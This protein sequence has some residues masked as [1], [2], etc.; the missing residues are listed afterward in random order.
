MVQRSQGRTDA[1][2]LLPVMRLNGAFYGDY[3][4]GMIHA[5]STLKKGTVDQPCYLTSLFKQ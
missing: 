3:L 5:E 2:R 1:V 4:I